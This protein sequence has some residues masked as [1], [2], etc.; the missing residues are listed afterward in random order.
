MDRVFEPYGRRN[1]ALLARIRDSGVN[2]IKMLLDY[3]DKKLG[4]PADRKAIHE[5]LAQAACTPGFLFKDYV[6]KLELLSDHRN[7]AQH[8][9]NNPP[10]NEASL[11]ELLQG[12][13]PNNWM[14]SFLRALHGNRAD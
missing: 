3:A 4:S 11:E 1:Q 6:K 7:Q 13:W 14:V 12:V 8:P 10:Y 9:E 5:A 2:P